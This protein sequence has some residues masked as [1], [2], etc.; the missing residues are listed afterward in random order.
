MVPASSP[1]RH[2]QRIQ[3]HRAALELVDDRLQDA[4]VH[5]VEAVFV[6]VEELQRL[7]HHLH[8]EDAVRAHLGEVADAPQQPVGHARGAAGPL[9][10]LPLAPRSVAVTSMMRAL[11]SI[12]RARSA[13]G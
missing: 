9:R 13:A 10:Q 7:A 6:D 11:R 5:C 12:M 2:G 4:G 1:E 8:L 3:S